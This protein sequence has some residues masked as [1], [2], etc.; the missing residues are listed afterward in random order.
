[1]LSFFSHDI[2]NLFVILCVVHQRLAVSQRTVVLAK[3]L[4]DRGNFGEVEELTLALKLRNDSI[5]ETTA[6]GLLSVEGLVE[7]KNLRSKTFAHLFGEGQGRR[8]FG[9]L[10]RLHE[11]NHKVSV[12]GSINEV[13]HC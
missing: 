12:G 13:Y 1:V 4:G 10:E 5:D 8:A 3:K 9:G 11:W 2:L 7:Q 6:Q